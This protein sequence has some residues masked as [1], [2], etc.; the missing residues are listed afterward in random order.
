MCLI[1]HQQV[2]KSLLSVVIPQNMKRWL[3]QKCYIANSLLLG[4]A[5]MIFLQAVLFP[6]T[7]HSI[8]SARDWGQVS[9]QPV[10][11]LSHCSHTNSYWEEQKSG[12]KSG[13][14]IIQQNSSSQIFFFQLQY[15]DTTKPKVVPILSTTTKEQ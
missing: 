9:Q 15:F 3:Y 7:F 4:D 14:K 10:L 13:D 6:S 12:S 11:S 2:L 8:E 5:N 1:P